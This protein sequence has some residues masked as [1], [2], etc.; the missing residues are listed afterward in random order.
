MKRK[1]RRHLR[2]ES[3]ISWFVLVSALDVFMTWAILRFSAEGTTRNTMIEGNP[4]ARWVIHHWGIRGMV[5]F[6]FAMVAVVV[7][8]A[9][10]VGHSRPLMARLLLFAGTAIVGSV[11]AYSLM[12]LLKNL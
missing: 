9:E 5:Y 11:V 10:I 6:K 4:I 3:E 1:T 8:I 2:F 7:V 12:L